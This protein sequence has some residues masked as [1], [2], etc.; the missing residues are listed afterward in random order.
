MN[1]RFILDFKDPKVNQQFI[2]KRKKTALA[3]CA[4]ILL[5]RMIIITHLIISYATDDGITLKRMLLY[6]IGSIFHAIILVVFWKYPVQTCQLLAF[7]I[8]LSFQSFLFLQGSDLPIN[9][10]SIEGARNLVGVFNI[11][12]LSGAF[13]N[14]SWLITALGIVLMMSST[15]VYYVII[16]HFPLQPFILQFLLF[17][18]LI[19]YLTYY[20]E[21]LL[22]NEFL[23]SRENECMHKQMKLII[24]EMPEGVL[25]YTKDSN[26]I[27]MANN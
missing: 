15:I 14:F 10:S 23:A 12:A 1:S 11:T 7:S 16:F 9:P 13:L 25:L 17:G 3:V 21:S 26:K 18:G 24:N 8:M 6:L 5:S 2:E 20:N 27:L 4:L 19:I 22:K